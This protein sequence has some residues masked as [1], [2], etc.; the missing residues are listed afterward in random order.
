MSLH[1]PEAQSSTMGHNNLVAVFV[2]IKAEVQQHV[3]SSSLCHSSLCSRPITANPWTCHQA[4]VMSISSA[5]ERQL[6][7]LPNDAA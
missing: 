5:P 3:E 6:E 1:I 2:E 4:E 7:G